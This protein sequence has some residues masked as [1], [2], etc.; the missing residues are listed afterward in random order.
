M[1]RHKILTKLS[2]NDD[3]YFCKKHY[4]IYKE[5]YEKFV[6]KFCSKKKTL[7]GIVKFT[8]FA[9]EYGFKN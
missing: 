7:C 2:S 5:I 6:G 3:N 1:K 8:D 9:N 4:K